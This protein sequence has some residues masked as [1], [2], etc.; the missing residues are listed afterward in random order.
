MVHQQRAGLVDALHLF[1][2]VRFPARQSKTVGVFRFC[3]EPVH[4]N[5]I[6][7]GRR[8]VKSQLMEGFDD[9]VTGGSACPHGRCTSAYCK[10]RTTD[11]V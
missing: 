9:L 1:G 2:R 4:A 7:H 11:A 5:H 10:A 8:Q 6:L 3:Q